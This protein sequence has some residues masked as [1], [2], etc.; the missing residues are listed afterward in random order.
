M[1]ARLS[2]TLSIHSR[3]DGAIDRVDLSH[4]D[5]LGDDLLRVDR[6]EFSHE[7]IAQFFVLPQLWPVPNGILPD[8]LAIDSA[9]WLEA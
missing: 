4:A 2:A 9:R 8:P 1:R 6:M 5:R 3:S 7:D